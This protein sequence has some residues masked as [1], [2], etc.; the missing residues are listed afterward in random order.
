MRK[1][2][3]TNMN[4]TGVSMH[5]IGVI[6]IG[7]IVGLIARAL[8]PGK[9]VAGF[10]L[11]SLVGVGGAVVGQYSGQALG[12]YLPQE[13]AGFFMSVIGAMLILLIFH[14]FRRDQSS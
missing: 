10:I 12:F 9:D 13:P 11:T 14:L 3:I 1:L 6:F 7:F 5:I 2:T 8:M 4:V